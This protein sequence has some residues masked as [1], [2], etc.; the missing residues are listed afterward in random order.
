[1][2]EIICVTDR[3]LC[4]DNFTDRL[5]KLCC[6]GIDRLILREKDLSEAE[7]RE[8]AKKALAVCVKYGVQCSLHSFTDTAKSLGARQIHLPLPLLRRLEDRGS[9]YEIGASV[10]SPEEAKEAESLGADYLIAGHIFETFCKEGLPGRG[11]DFL[12]RTAAAVHIPVYAIG[13]ITEKNAA[14]VIQ[15]GAKGIAVRSGLM[16]C[17][18]CKAYINKLRRQTDEVKN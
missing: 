17:N 6:S 9:F 2:S 13:G 3:R 8:L 18:D 1:M 11:L 14:S 5:E 10:H 15:A 12:A 4:R 16:V 7:Y